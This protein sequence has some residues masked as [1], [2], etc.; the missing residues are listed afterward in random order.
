M[1]PPIN[2][3]QPITHPSIPRT[4]S[5]S[6]S[7]AAFNNDNTNTARKRLKSA[8]TDDQG[9]A[10]EDAIDVDMLVEGLGSGEED[11]DGIDWKDRGGGGDQE[12]EPTRKVGV[13]GG[14]LIKESVCALS[15]VRKLRENVRKE[16]HKGSSTLELSHSLS[17]G[18]WKLMRSLACVCLLCRNVEDVPEPHLY[19]PRRLRS[20]PLSRAARDQDVHDQPCRHSVRP[21]PS[22]A[23]FFSSRPISRRL[24]YPDFT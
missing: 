13:G 23:L 17:Y 22:S 24:L 11:D 10:P 20:L 5:S 14:G 7:S 19:R 15:S 3:F 1:F 4:P 2:P 21:V 12:V 9:K 18:K 8:F 16:A 6:S